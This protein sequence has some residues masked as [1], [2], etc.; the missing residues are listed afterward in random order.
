MA[1][2]PLKTVQIMLMD[3]TTTF[4]V[5]DTTASALGTAVIAQFDAHQTLVFPQSGDNGDAIIKVPF[6]AVAVLAVT[7]QMAEVEVADP[8]FCEESEESGDGGNP[9]L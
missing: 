2:K 9:D 7:K 6:H 1:I 3:G 8:Y 5:A 4:T